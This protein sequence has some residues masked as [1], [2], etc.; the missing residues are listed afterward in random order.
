MPHVERLTS[1][2]PFFLLL[3][4]AI[5]EPD[6]LPGHEVANI[7]GR[8][9]DVDTTTTPEDVWGGE[10]FGGGLYTFPTAASSMEVIS[11]SASDAAAGTGAQTVRIDGLD[12][13]LNPV[14]AEASLNGTTAVALATPFFRVNSL[15]VTRAG[16]G[17]TNAGEIRVRGAGAG[18]I[19][20]V[21]PIG[22]A[23]ASHGIYTVKR[24]F[25]AY[26]VGSSFAV[27]RGT[28]SA[29]AVELALYQRFARVATSPWLRRWN[30]SL[31]SSGG[32]SR[33]PH[34]IPQPMNEGA[35]MRFTCDFVTANNTQVS[36]RVQMVLI[37][38]RNG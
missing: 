34:V 17:L 33:F 28:G 22:A 29:T 12:G 1:D 3:A 27:E 13:Q 23:L 35:D 36:M 31:D 26:V 16:S 15:R 6:L 25:T 11:S 32:N 30:F 21:I 5:R 7:R 8:N 37:R 4:R 9:Y 38:N 20:G 19:Y 2:Y 24:G 10:S 14:T 18:T